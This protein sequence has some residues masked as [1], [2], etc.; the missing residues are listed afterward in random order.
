M[1]EPFQ[2][3]EEDKSYQQNAPL[4]ARFGSERGQIGHVRMCRSTFALNFIDYP[5]AE[6]HG[7][8]RYYR[9]YSVADLGAMGS[10]DDMITFDFTTPDSDKEI[11]Y[12]FLVKGIAGWRVRLIEAP[13]GGAATPTGQFAL[14]NRNR[15]S[16]NTSLVSDG[17]TAGQINY[18]STLATGGTS[19]WDEFLAGNTTNKNASTQ[20][21]TAQRDELVLK[22][23]TK[24]Q[25]SL[26]GTDAF[27]AAIYIDH[28]EHTPRI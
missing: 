4:I 19:L 7:G 5:H 1:A 11:H 10:P 12:T 13:S 6:I 14:L 9:L 22:Q 26:F 18:D 8:S 16:S 25:L 21:A 15:R 23:A 3:T 24:Y 2:F 20:A 28:Y 17:S 27:P